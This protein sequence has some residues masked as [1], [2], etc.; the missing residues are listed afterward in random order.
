VEK[1]ELTSSWAQKVQNF[2]AVVSVSITKTQVC[3]LFSWDGFWFHKYC[4]VL[5]TPGGT[6]AGGVVSVHTQIFFLL[7]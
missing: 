6:S 3:V 1:L 2:V 4:I 5:L 7:N